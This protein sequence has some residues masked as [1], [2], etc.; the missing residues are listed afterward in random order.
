MSELMRVEGNV[1]DMSTEQVR[2]IQEI[3]AA[4]IIAQKFRRNPI[5]AIIRIE[6][7]C[8][9]PK[10]AE[11]A[12]YTYPRGGQKIS[13]PSIRLAEVLIQNWGNCKAGIEEVSRGKGESTMRAYAWDLETNTMIEKKF[14]VA[15]VR[16]TK[17]GPV[18]LKEE[19]DI[20]EMTANM[21]ARRLRACILGVIPQ[22]VVET[23]V[24]QVRETIRGN[25]DV[26]IQDRLKPVIEALRKVGVNQSMIEMK[27]D[28]KFD[29]VSE[30]ELV[31]L[32]GIY[33]SIKDGV[34]KV[35]DWFKPKQPTENSMSLDAGSA[36]RSKADPEPAP[37]KKA[38]EPKSQQTLSDP[39]PGEDSGKKPWDK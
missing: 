25:S 35:A 19:R 22:D 21:G 30:D 39:I 2:A 10:M 8:K 13:G 14:T 36:P 27:F 28:H 9:R 31:E 15:H 24:D 33:T 26:P 11:A 20:Y 16:D 32:R 17:K 7:A 18:K 34:S 37:E 6:E 38:P 23:A 4:M 12:L 3:Q 5:E 1:T 29:V